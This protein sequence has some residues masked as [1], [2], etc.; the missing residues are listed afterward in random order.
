MD[1]ESCVT[2]MASKA[3]TGES[4]VEEQEKIT[5]VS[6]N[7]KRCVPPNTDH[8]YCPHRSRVYNDPKPYHKTLKVRQEDPDPKVTKKTIRVSSRAPSTGLSPVGR[9]NLNKNEEVEE[10]ILSITSAVHMVE[11]V[12]PS[13]KDE[14]G[15]SIGPDAESPK[16]V[17]DLPKG[18]HKN[19]EPA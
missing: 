2:V 11:K 16:N 17:P 9:S 6:V 3:E 12:L 1:T 5:V 10:T 19:H 8:V 4:P 7:Q 14:N 15:E 13:H 18:D